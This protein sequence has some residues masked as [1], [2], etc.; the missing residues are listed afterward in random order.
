[1]LG[2]RFRKSNREEKELE[3]KERKYHLFKLRILVA[4]FRTIL[5]KSGC[6]QSL[7]MANEITLVFLSVTVENLMDMVR[8]PR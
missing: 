3:R 8:D 2:N 7:F 5:A 4:C 1:M 6:G